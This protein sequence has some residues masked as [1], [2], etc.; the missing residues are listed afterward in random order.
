MAEVMRKGSE[1]GVEEV[2]EYVLKSGRQRG[3]RVIEA[4]DARG[5]TPLHASAANWHVGVVERLL[6]ARASVDAAMA[7]GSTPLYVCAANGHVG[8]VERL[9]AARRRS[10]PSGVGSRLWR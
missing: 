6:A 1:R 4:T 10:M 8:V 3:V 5:A 2:V 9:L 7:D